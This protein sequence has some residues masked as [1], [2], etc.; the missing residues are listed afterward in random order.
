MLRRRP[1]GHA[2]RQSSAAVG[3]V[4]G[5]PGTDVVQAAAAFARACAAFPQA[6][7]SRLWVV[8]ADASNLRL[9][10]T[11]SVNVDV[12]PSGMAAPKLRSYL[13]TLVNDMVARPVAD[14]QPLPV[15]WDTSS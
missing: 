14:I 2:S 11:G 8:E 3:L 9:G 1:R 7:V 15:V 13:Q 10:P 4:H 6:E 12:V 5:T